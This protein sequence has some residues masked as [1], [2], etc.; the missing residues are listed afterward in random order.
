MALVETVQLEQKYDGCVVL[1]GV[2]LKIERGDVFALIGPTGAGKTTLIKLLD[3]LEVPSSGIIYFDG[4]D[5]TCGRRERLKARRRMALVQQEPIVF[6][7]SVYDNIA[8]GLRWRHER[9]DIMKQKVEN[10]LELVGMAKYRNRS[11]TTLSGGEK[12][13]LAIARALIIEPELLLLDEPMANLD[14]NSVFEM[15]EV[16]A[17]II[18]EKKTTVLMTTH[19]MLQGQRFANKMGV[20]IDGKLQQ[21]GSANEIFFSPK[22]KEVAEF[23]GIKNVLGGVVLQKEGNLVTIDLNGTKIQAISEHEVGDRVYAIIKPE[24][25]TFLLSK[26]GSSARNVFKGKIA[27][28]TPAGTLVILEMD[29]G[30]PLLGL[31]TT[32]S[33]QELCL[34][35]GK[36][37]YASFKASMV[38]TIK[39]W[40]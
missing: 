40:R 6:A 17:Y 20:L 34:T 24:G 22:T 30:F 13:R 4:V 11:A 21:V 2:N 25:I 19:N 3:L 16:L 15:E 35:I 29:C 27:K 10:T 8:C 7:M 38:H 18:R 33:A 31:V 23:A 28:I 26:D 1:K 9:N 5:V 36:Q 37:V 32:K 14:P 39:R 12:Q